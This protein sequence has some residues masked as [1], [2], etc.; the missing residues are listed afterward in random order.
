[1]PLPGAKTKVARTRTRRSCRPV[2]LGADLK[3]RSGKAVFTS[4]FNGG[5]AER[6]GISPGDELVAIDGLRVS[7]SGSDTHI[8][9][10][11]VNDKSEIT[12][13]RGDELLRLRL[14]WKA[15]PQTTCYLEIDA[16]AGDDEQRFRDAWLN[17]SQNA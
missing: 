1:M 3:T 16:D 6:A 2:W 7:A 8:R 11:R 5:P 12:V 13:F 4:V 17:N 10:F 9:R 14:T 15:A